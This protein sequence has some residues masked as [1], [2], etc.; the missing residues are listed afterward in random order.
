MGLFNTADIL[1]ILAVTLIV[2][3][4]Q[5]LP[6]VAR[7][8]AKAIRMF[9]EASREIQHQIEM[10]DWDLDRSIKSSSKKPAESAQATEPS[11]YS[12]PTS[13]DGG[14]S[15]DGSLAVTHESAPVETPVTEAPVI[16]GEPQVEAPPGNESVVDPKPETV[17]VTENPFPNAIT[18]IQSNTAVDDPAKRADAERYHREL[19]D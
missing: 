5:K 7:Y 10:A 16:E 8:V 2:F 18:E 12:Y 9:Q 13:H 19:F 6:E 11:G 14:G 15:Y 4:P 17:S 1:I 3:G